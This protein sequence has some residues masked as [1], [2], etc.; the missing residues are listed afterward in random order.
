MCGLRLS[1]L[2]QDRHEQ[3]FSLHI[4]TAAL[5][6]VSCWT[7]VGG[8]QSL[9]GQKIRAWIDSYGDTPFL[10]RRQPVNF[11]AYGSEAKE[12]KESQ[13]EYVNMC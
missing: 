2:I 13:L 4:G 5:L 8:T 11:H 3:S 7:L 12:Y 10:M 1:I 9:L 6:S